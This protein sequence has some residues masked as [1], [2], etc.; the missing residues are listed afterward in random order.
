MTTP[1]IRALRAHRNRVLLVLVTIVGGF[2]AWASFTDLARGVHL[3][4]TVVPD[5]RRKVVQ[6]QVTGIVR[7]VH[8]RDGQEV[9]E[10]EPIITLDQEKLLA[11]RRSLSRRRIELMLTK[12]RLQAELDGVP[13]M[14]DMKAYLAQF[15]ELDSGTVAA[16][17]QT[18]AHAATAA[19][20]A[21]LQTIDARKDKLIAE[22]AGIKRAL[23]ILGEQESLL[24]DR[25]K[26]FAP[27][28]ADGLYA[29]AEYLRLEQQ[30]LEMQSHIEDRA[31]AERAMH[32]EVAVL[33]AERERLH[34]DH[35]RRLSEGVASADVDIQQVKASNLR[36]E[37]DIASSIVRAPVHGQL[38]G[39]SA[40]TPGSVLN[41]G[42]TIGQIVPRDEPLLIEAAINPNDVERVKLGTGAEIRFAAYV[43][44]KASPLLSGKVVHIAKD[45][46]TDST[47]TGQRQQMPGYQ[48]RIVVEPEELAKL[49]H[50]QVLPGMQVE[51]FSDGGTRSVLDYFVSP[52][53]QLFERAMR[54]Y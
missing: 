50:F 1:A 7:I 10:G 35:R 5:T 32:G 15:P 9:A 33:N 52:V 39:F 43:P 54:E 42:Q 41:I 25:L 21:Q 12:A 14:P 26:A 24:R 37:M 31:T 29:R 30:L 16:L 20:R 48:I 49:G 4:G 44:R 51:V 40:T 47:E 11:E 22:I 34:Q 38:L 53:G 23:V 28:V 6:P 13:F 17:A 46:V 27:L 8:V 36:V 3:T 19:I 18:S 45:V 2:F